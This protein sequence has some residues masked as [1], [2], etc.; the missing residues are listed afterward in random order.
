MMFLLISIQ[1]MEYLLLHAHAPAKTANVVISRCCFEGRH[2]IVQKCVQHVYFSQFDQSNPYF[3]ALLL[4]LPLSM[5]KLP[6]DGVDAAKSTASL[7][8]AKKK[9]PLWD[10]LLNTD[11]HTRSNVAPS[12]R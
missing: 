7:H 1:R 9:R 10:V 11:C 5:L 2:E 6:N 8:R 12:W 3:V 4:S